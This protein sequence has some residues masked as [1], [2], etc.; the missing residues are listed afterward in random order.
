MRADEARGLTISLVLMP[1]VESPK[2]SPRV[3]QAM[4]ISSSAAL[5]ARSPMPLMVHSTCRAP[6]ARRPASWPPPGPD[7]CGNATLMMA[8]LSDIR[9]RVDAGG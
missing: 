7:R 8:C 9:A 5:P 1:R 3:L 2:K 4:T 6:A